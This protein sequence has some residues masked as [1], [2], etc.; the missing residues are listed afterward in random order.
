MKNKIIIAISSF[1]IIISVY[2]LIIWIAITVSWIMH[3]QEMDYRNGF[4][5]LI[6][7][8][9]RELVA[10]VGML[11]GSIGLLRS[12]NWARK[13][14]IAVLSIE[15]FFIVRVMVLFQTIIYFNLFLTLLYAATIIFLFFLPKF[16]EKELSLGNYEKI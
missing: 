9:L 10:G 1:Y 5:S 14:L 8:Y 15:I 7:G 11:V 2:L 3:P 13:L 16:P 4:V 12:K 6:I